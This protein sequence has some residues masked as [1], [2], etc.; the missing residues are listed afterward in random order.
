M[1]WCGLASVSLV[2]NELETAD[3]IDSSYDECWRWTRAMKRFRAEFFALPGRSE[4]ERWSASCD[5]AAVWW[6]KSV[7]D[8]SVRS[9]AFRKSVYTVETL[10][11]KIRLDSNSI[12]RVRRTWTQTRCHV[13]CRTWAKIFVCRQKKKNKTKQLE[14]NLKAKKNNGNGLSVSINLLSL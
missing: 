4:G 14:F 1:V 10:R 13:C 9:E 2:S 6:P 7:P 8:D 11:S 12:Q 3:A 5:S